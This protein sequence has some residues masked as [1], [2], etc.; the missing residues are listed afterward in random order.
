MQDPCIDLRGGYESV[1]KFAEDRSKPIILTT[2]GTASASS[3][4]PGQDI[5][6]PCN[7]LERSMTRTINA[8]D[9]SAASTFPEHTQWLYQG[10]KRSSIARN[11]LARKTQFGK[12]DAPDAGIVLTPENVPSNDRWA[13]WVDITGRCSLLFPSGHPG[14]VKSSAGD[15]VNE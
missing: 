1:I 11:A 3:L 13:D 8:A 14:L 9:Q 12:P 15:S 4:L 10:D 2:R 5:K 7:E 6:I